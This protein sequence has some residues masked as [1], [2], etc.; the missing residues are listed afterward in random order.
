V[1][2]GSHGANAADSHGAFAKATCLGQAA[3]GE[4]G[5]SQ[6]TKEFGKGGVIG[7]Q[8]ALGNSKSG[9]PHL[10]RTV[11]I[12]EQEQHVASHL[13]HRCSL[14]M[15]RR[16]TRANRDRPFERRHGIGVWSGIAIEQADQLERAAHTDRVPLCALFAKAQRLV[17]TQLRLGEPLEL[18]QDEGEP[19]ER[20]GDERAVAAEAAASNGERALEERNRQPEFAASGAY[21]PGVVECLP[22][23]DVGEPESLLFEAHDARRQ[24]QR[25]GIAALAAV[26]ARLDEQILR[27]QQRQRIGGS[28]RFEPRD[29]CRCQVVGPRVRAG[30]ERLSNR[31]R[32]LAMGQARCQA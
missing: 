32:G 22:G 15:P 29:G 7:A 8:A 5:E 9:R 19:V 24:A 13:H 1:T 14:G 10:V 16:E 26:Y 20:L 12:A 4:L 21:E 23:F 2:A 11:R 17:E 3:G 6:T 31:G 28:L 25:P 18:N 30:V 27:A